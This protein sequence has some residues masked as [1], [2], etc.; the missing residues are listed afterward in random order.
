MNQTRSNGNAIEIESLVKVYKGAVR[1]LDGIDLVVPAGSVFGLL[2]PNGAGKTTAVKI[3]TTLAR[4]TSGTVRV[5]GNDVVRQATQVRNAIGVVGQ[6]SGVDVNLTGRENLRLQ[7]L[8]RSIHGR[9]LKHRVNELLDQ[10]GLAD[11]AKRVARNYSGGMQRRLDIAT[12]LVHRPQ[13][14]FLDEPTT[15]LDPEVRTEMWQEIERLTHEEG[16][17]IL[18]TTHYL[19]EADQLA[20]KLAILDRGKVVAKGSPEELKEEL[21]GDTVHVELREDAPDGT[22]RAALES[23]QGIRQLDHDV[24]CLRARVEHGARAVPLVL[25]AL[26]AKGLAVDSVAVSRPSLDDVYMRYT[27]REF[28]RADEEGA[29]KQNPSGEEKR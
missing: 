6:T 21:E 10:F 9:E 14:L 12:A 1:A 22:I 15:G 11:S 2:G 18:L 27:G 8:I 25:Q 24:H 13:V 19:E 17:T 16:L 5:A 28:A 23:V 20:A 7:G 3:A 4:P 26:E 29:R